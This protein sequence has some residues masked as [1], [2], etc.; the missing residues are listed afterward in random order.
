ML[1]H[2]AFSAL[3]ESEVIK[4]KVKVKFA[5]VNLISQHCYLEGNLKDLQLDP[6]WLI[7]EA[8]KPCSTL[9]K[10]TYSPWFSEKG[11]ATPIIV[12]F[13]VREEFICMKAFMSISK[14]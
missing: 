6:N 13:P 4:A 3:L 9:Q 1:C 12:L 11:I 7:M 2:I 5:G 14:L 10:R 8:F